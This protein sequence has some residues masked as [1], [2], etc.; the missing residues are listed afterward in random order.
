MGAGS[1]DGNTRSSIAASSSSPWS[2]SL[3]PSP[4]S[5]SSS[6]SK[7]FS[8]S[9]PEGCFLVDAAEARAIAGTVI[10]LN[11]LVLIRAPRGAAEEDEDEEESAFGV[12]EEEP[13]AEGSVAVAV[14]RASDAL[15][16]SAAARQLGWP[17]A[18]LAPRSEV[19]R[20][21][22][23]RFAPGGVPP[24]GH[25][26]AGLRT[27]VCSRAVQRV[28]GLAGREEEGERKGEDKAGG[29]RPTGR[30]ESPASPS[31]PAGETPL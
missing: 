22:R 25:A 14:L 24:L 26:A 7:S 23:Y 3:W 10:S 29:R 31:S 11:S 19:P 18:R 5:Y 1:R 21:L 8:S 2:S 12:E 15:D 9:L 20:L 6:A 28:P 30:G 4:T 17:R 13:D 16:L 27:L